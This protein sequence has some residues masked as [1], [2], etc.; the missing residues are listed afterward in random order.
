M[1][2][3]TQGQ[4]IGLVQGIYD[5]LMSNPEMGMGDMGDCMEAAE[6]LVRNWAH[7]NGIEIE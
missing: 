4:F 3:L 7:S 5:Q 1:E 6:D 2:T